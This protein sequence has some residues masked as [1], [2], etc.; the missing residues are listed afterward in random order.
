MTELYNVTIGKDDV[1]GDYLGAVYCV[2]SDEGGAVKGK[3]FYK[4]LRSVVQRVR[5][6]E[7]ERRMFPLPT[8][9]PSP[10]ILPNGR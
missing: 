1:S 4:V 6:K 2:S 5:D 9:E 8:V 3:S 10:I 7:K